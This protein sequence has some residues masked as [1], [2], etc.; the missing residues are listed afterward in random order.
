MTQNI[1]NQQPVPIDELAGTFGDNTPPVQPQAQNAQQ[2]SQP[3]S[4]PLPSNASRPGEQVAPSTGDIPGRSTSDEPALP[5]HLISRAQRLGISRENINRFHD[6]ESLTY[7]LDLFTERRMQEQE[8]ELQRLRN[9]QPQAAKTQ[10]PAEQAGFP[11]PSQLDP[12]EY[13]DT[14]VK[15]LQNQQKA[16]Q[17]L[18]ERL[19]KLDQEE[20]V[21]TL[22][23][24]V[25]QIVAESYQH[26]RLVAQAESD[27]R[28]ALVAAG[29]S[30]D[31]GHD[32]GFLDRFSKVAGAQ[33]NAFIE[34]GL[35]A[36]TVRELA[37]QLIPKLLGG[38]QPQVAPQQLQQTTLQPQQTQRPQQ[39]PQPQRQQPRAQNGQ[40]VPVGAPTHSQ[41]PAVNGGHLRGLFHA[42]NVDPGPE[43]TSPDIDL[44]GFFG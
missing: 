24:V 43:D 39:Q 23:P 41:Q 32:P 2:P 31:V 17:Q 8:A 19:K 3:Q 6:A 33:R 29:H 18:E 12:N 42:N 14:L 34:A 20:I 4:Q 28:E 38:R 25:H 40:F 21:K 11:D 13:G 37:D 35:P 15:Y 5:T 7:A 26:Q 9:Q 1:Q 27:L 44:N 16:Y 36:P 10:T 30:A 22:N